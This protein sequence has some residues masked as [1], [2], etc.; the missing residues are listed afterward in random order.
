[1][2]R[3]RTSA[4]SC[5][6]SHRIELS[7][8]LKE[9]YLRKNEYKSGGISWINRFGRITSNVHIATA[10]FAHEKYLSLSYTITDRYTK[11]RRNYN[12]KIEL[13]SIPSNLGKGEVLY[14]LCPKTGK[15][16]RALY[17]A[18]GYPKWKSREA[19]PHRLYYELQR[20]SKYNLANNRYW[21]IT[22]RLD[23]IL[24]EK[25][26]TLSY[27]NQ[28]TKKAQ[29]IE[30]LIDKQQYYNRERFQL[31]NAPIWFRKVMEGRSQKVVE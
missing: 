17:S 30:R 31:S 28:P 9:G 14:F 11:K 26:L 16:C 23:K 10:N 3:Q 19:Y 5:E 8:L 29:L 27:N 15:R 12:C 2:G 4:Q 24:H 21:A 7:F 25:H 6:N 1:M 18:Y 13:T 20:S 22:H